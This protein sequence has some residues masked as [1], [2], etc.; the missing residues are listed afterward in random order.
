[1]PYLN[2]GTI[3]CISVS[4]MSFTKNFVLP[5]SLARRRHFV[6]DYPITQSVNSAMLLYLV[7]EGSSVREYYTVHRG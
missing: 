4:Q 1:M 6:L 7:W 3:Y 2:L 5:I